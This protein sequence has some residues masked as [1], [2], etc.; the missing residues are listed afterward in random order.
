[1]RE[2]TKLELKEFEE[3]CRILRD[4]GN[5][6]FETYVADSVFYLMVGPSHD[7]QLKKAQQHI[8]ASH[9]VENCGGGGW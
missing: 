2:P 1:M 9:F 8:R 3:A 7:E 6:G 4:L 5:K